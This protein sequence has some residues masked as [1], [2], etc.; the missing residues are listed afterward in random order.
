VETDAAGDAGRRKI[1]RICMPL[2]AHKA[3]P[4]GRAGEPEFHDGPSGLEVELPSKW[5]WSTSS[6]GQ[7]VEVLCC[8]T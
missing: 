5:T 1:A 3:E 2:D 8:R 6:I 4:L 7:S